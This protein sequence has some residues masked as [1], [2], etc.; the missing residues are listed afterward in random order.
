MEDTKI[1]IGIDRLIEILKQ[2]KK[3]DI[4]SAAKELNQPMKTVEEWA[5]LLEK[6]KL[7]KIEYKLTKIYLI[8]KGES[9]DA[10][11]TK[12]IFNEAKKTIERINEIKN[13]TEQGK[14]ELQEIEN[15]LK[16]IKELSLVNSTDAS[17]LKK[18]IENLE[19]DY[20]NTI[21]KGLE[22]IQ[23]IKTE[24]SKLD[25]KIKAQN[26]DFSISPQE[27]E[28]LKN[29]ED[30]IEQQ[31]EE[32]ENTFIEFEKQ[33]EEIKTKMET[34]K[35]SEEILEIKQELENAKEIHKEIN[36][37][38]EA[39]K[40]EQKELQKQLENISA[41]I[42]KKINEK[43]PEYKKD[44]LNEIKKMGDEAAKQKRKTMQNLS[45]LLYT[46][47]KENKKIEQLRLKKDDITERL[48]EISRDYEEMASEISK[49]EEEF[50]RKGEEIKE[51]LEKSK[52]ILSMIQNNQIPKIN[53]EDL[54]V[55]FQM[56]YDLNNT[57]AILSEKLQKLNLEAE[58]LINGLNELEMKMK[59]AQPQSKEELEIEVYDKDSK[60]VL[61]KIRLSE[62]E[63]REFER[64]REELRSLVRRM[65]E[66]SKSNN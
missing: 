14:Q 32:A 40:E 22:K 1:S 60:V 31:I 6:E 3:M 55:A 61:E 25:S 23:K 34:E 39:I 66:E 56:L 21:E 33:L 42:E 12:E 18:N 54:E 26:I 62:E 37:G 38:L 29:I 17:E 52:Q 30:K 2:K 10:T 46:I 35:D 16:K 28:L 36:E 7:I 65:W 51:K 11:E 19:T 20:K 45:E 5:E 43:S 49:K 47:Q 4:D 27:E 50:K 59:T 58:S 57:H 48:S 44:K 8:W 13:K 53:T 9:W 15:Q 24:L 41:R 64:K 63:A